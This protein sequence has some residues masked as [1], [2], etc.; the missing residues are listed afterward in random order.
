MAILLLFPFV[1]R[2]G[3]YWLAKQWCMTLVAVMRWLP[4]LSCLRAVPGADFW[5]ATPDRVESRFLDSAN[6]LKPMLAS[7][8]NEI[9]PGAVRAGVL[10][11][12]GRV[13]RGPLHAGFAQG[14]QLRPARAVYGLS[15]EDIADRK[16]CKRL[17]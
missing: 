16:E 17:P 14:L 15:V 3:P 9:E 11:H 1:G 12:L 10:P 13:R 8:S 6:D 5:L 4:G 2:A 7:Y